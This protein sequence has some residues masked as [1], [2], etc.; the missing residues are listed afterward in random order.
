MVKHDNFELLLT[1]IG[2]EYKFHIATDIYWSRMT[3]S[4]Y[5]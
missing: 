2:Q 1:S 4:N 3:I 5:Y